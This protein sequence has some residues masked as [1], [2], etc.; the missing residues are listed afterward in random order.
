MLDIV[1]DLLAPLLTVRLRLGEW[2]SGIK[3]RPNAPLVNRL[4]RASATTQ[5]TIFSR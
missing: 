3:K 5:A 2:T 1:P 4:S